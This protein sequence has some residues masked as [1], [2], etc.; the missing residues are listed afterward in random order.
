[1]FVKVSELGNHQI[2]KYDIDKHDFIDYFKKLY[3]EQNLSML[4][5]KSNDYNLLKHIS[6]NFR[7]E[8]IK[9]THNLKRHKT[10]TGK[11]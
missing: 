7:K 11:D 8:N 2:Y 4:H 6:I 1:M 5:L 10:R 3:K 9:I